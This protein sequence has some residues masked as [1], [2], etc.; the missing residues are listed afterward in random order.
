MNYFNRKQRMVF[1]LCLPLCFFSVSCGNIKTFWL[2]TAANNALDKDDLDGAIEHYEQLIEM[3]PE[4]QSYYWNLGVAY[5]RKGN[6]VKAKKQIKKLKEIGQ[7]ELAYE[8]EN[9]ISKLIKE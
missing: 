5:Y 6:I 3:H 9:E 8:L 7:F 2:S 1:Y 4:D